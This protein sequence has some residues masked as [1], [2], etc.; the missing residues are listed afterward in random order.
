MWRYVDPGIACSGRGGA[1]AWKA[2]STWEGIEMVADGR[3]AAGGSLGCSDR[4]AGVVL[5]WIGGAGTAGR[6]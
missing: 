5:A 1:D 3:A 6:Q 4:R 2:R